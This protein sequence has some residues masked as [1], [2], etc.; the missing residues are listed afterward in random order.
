MSALQEESEENTSLPLDPISLFNY[1]ALGIPSN[2]IACSS[3]ADFYFEHVTL[4]V[5]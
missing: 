2:K 4:I 1:M 5:K 3:I